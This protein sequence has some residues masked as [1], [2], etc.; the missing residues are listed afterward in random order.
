MF[1]TF[2]SFLGC[3]ERGEGINCEFLLRFGKRDVGERIF[4][5]AGNSVRS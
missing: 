5:V 1:E 4:G 3:E 2:D